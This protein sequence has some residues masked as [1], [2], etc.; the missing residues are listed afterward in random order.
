MRE[1]ALRLTTQVPLPETRLMEHA[2]WYVEHEKT[3]IKYYPFEE[4]D[5][6][7]LEGGGGFYL[8]LLRTNALDRKKM[9]NQDI[10]IYFNA[11]DGLLD[12]KVK[13]LDHLL[14]ACAS[15]VRVDCYN[16]PECMETP[17]P[18]CPANPGASCKPTH[19]RV[20]MLSVHA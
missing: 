6:D 9:T 20:C 16:D 3:H 11:F 1:C 8:F 14:D 4:E 17:V 12:K 5:G 15:F 7:G 2:F 13:D 19:A 18:T 10:N